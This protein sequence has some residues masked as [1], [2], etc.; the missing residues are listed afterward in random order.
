MD[1]IVESPM[2]VY[3]AGMA[4]GIGLAALALLLMLG[5]LAG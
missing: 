5:V 2:V 3:G 4:I 1:S